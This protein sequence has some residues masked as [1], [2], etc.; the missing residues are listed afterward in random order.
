[1]NQMIPHQKIRS[2]ID[3]IVLECMPRTVNRT[4]AIENLENFLLSCKESGQT[5]DQTSFGLIS[6]LKNN[7]NLSLDEFIYLDM[8][9]FSREYLKKYI[10]REISKRD[11]QKR[12]YLVSV[13]RWSSI[14]TQIAKEY[15]SSFDGVITT[16]AFMTDISKYL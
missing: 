10:M 13:A 3:S 7:F 6:I 14:A 16:E 8:T 9:P 2:L 15:D 5:L 12:E 4:T 1:M 11:A